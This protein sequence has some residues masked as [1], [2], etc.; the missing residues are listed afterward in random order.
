MTLPYKFEG[1]KG[2]EN[3]ND[4]RYDVMGEMM[5]SGAI[6]STCIFVS[7]Y[8]CI[9]V[10]FKC[11][12]TNCS[13]AVSHCRLF[14]HTSLQFTQK[15]PRPLPPSLHC[16]SQHHIIISINA[17]IA[18]PHLSPLPPHRHH[19]PP[20]PHP[21]TTTHHHDLPLLL[22]PVGV[23][24]RP[25][26]PLRPRPRPLPQPLHLRRVEPGSPR[27]RPLAALCS[28]TMLPPDPCHNGQA[29]I[30]ARI[31]AQPP[32]SQSRPPLFLQANHP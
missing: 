25:P 5:S 1:M 17:L 30:P 16:N 32:P 29:V 19:I 21:T 11:S 31:T 14:Q 8:L 2:N 3:G 13:F 7:L 26:H 6:Q 9:F 15:C 27:H 20:P 12:V 24:P 22:D 28:N 4:I 23:Q 10:F 18:L